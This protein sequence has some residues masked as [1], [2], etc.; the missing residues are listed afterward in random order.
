MV[1]AGQTRLVTQLPAEVI[2]SPEKPSAGDGDGSLIEKLSKFDQ[3]AWTE[4]ETGLSL[5]SIDTE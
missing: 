1:R 4:G 5:R 2:Y 3:E